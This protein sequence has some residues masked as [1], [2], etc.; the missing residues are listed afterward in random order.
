M[1]A[2]GPLQP[3]N[4]FALASNDLFAHGDM[5]ADDGQMV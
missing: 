3:G 4:D 1:L 5:T 2:T